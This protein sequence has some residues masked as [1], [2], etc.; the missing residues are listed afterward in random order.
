ML[1]LGTIIDIT[2]ILII[3]IS[4][5]KIN[6]NKTIVTK[7]N[8]YFNYKTR[9]KLLTETEYKFYNLLNSIAQKQNLIVFSQVALNQIVKSNTYREL[10]K[11]GGKSIDFVIIDKDRNIKLCIELDDY[12]HNKEKRKIRDNIVNEIFNET[13]TKLLRVP[14]DKTFT[15]ERLEKTIKESL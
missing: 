3:I 6:K 4:K 8:T 2:I 5:I 9:E 13:N 14:I 1:I 12:T 11:I 10:K 15:V 7:T